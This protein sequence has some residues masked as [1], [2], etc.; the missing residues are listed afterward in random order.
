MLVL[1]DCGSAA[2]AVL[3]FLFVAV[4]LGMAIGSLGIHGSVL[5]ATEDFV[6]D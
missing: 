6:V 2:L 5:S 1:L 4:L 3:H